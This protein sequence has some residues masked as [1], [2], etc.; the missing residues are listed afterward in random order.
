MELESLNK[1]FNL[2]IA[3]V[4]LPA[5]LTTKIYELQQKDPIGYK[6]SNYGGWHSKSF[7]Y[8]QKYNRRD[9]TWIVDTL[10]GIDNMM[11]EKNFQFSR[12]WFNINST[13]NSNNWHHHGQHPFVGVL[14]ISVP[15]NSGDI[16]F[17]KD[18]EV[19]SYT[20]SAGEFVAFPGLLMHRVLENQS[21]ENRI[22]LAI[23]FSA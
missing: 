21:T 20:P 17:E 1:Q 16:E 13:G 14:Y 18:N 5:G 3:K 15:P 19:F 10:T 4:D 7:V 2:W 12:G 9:Y 22:S 6:K 8:T 23:N 11:K